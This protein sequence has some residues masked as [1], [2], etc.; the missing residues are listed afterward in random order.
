[1]VTQYLDIGGL[2][3]MVK[4]LCIELQKKNISVE[5]LCLNQPDEL[6]CAVLKKKNI[7]I[8]VIPQKG[9]L[10]VI[11]F[12]KCITL[13]KKKHFDVIHAHS[14]CY[15]TAALLSILSGG[16]RLVFT[17]HGMIIF[18]R[19]LDRVEDSFA[20]L[21]TNNLVS[22]S[23]EIENAMRRWLLFSRCKFS[24]IPNVIDINIFK[25]VNDEVL[26]KRLIDKY[27]M[28]EDRI[29]FGSVGRMSAVKNYSMVIR[30]VKR[31]VD[32]GITNILFVLVGGKAVGEHDQQDHLLYLVKKLKL[33]KYIR[34]LGVQYN[35]HEILPLFRFFVLSSFT[36]GTSISLLEAQACG[37]PVVVTDVGGNKNV[38]KNGI[39]GYL[40][41]SDDDEKMAEYMRRLIEDQELCRKMGHHGRD[42]VVRNYSV[43]VMAEKYLQIYNA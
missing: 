8:H 36:E 13:I 16:K 23:E 12:S 39:N 24:T 27:N 4:E 15:L 38:V 33:S 40:C 37:I 29:I 31:L 34:F 25:P 19:F 28:P 43:Q 14:G 17:A 5:L 32:S 18:N 1:M 9:R 10:D 35:I 7:P 20:G 26:K 42:R 21:F 11:F 3:N 41:P 6:F 22:V 2:E 30:A